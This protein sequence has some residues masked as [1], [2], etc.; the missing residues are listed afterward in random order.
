MNFVISGFLVQYAFT[1]KQKYY[2]TIFLGK[3]LW[4]QKENF[5]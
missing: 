2:L 3:I 1:G 4:F 5:L